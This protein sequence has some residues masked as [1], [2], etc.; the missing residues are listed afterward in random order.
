[1][2]VEKS[3]RVCTYIHSTKDLFLERNKEGKERK[4]RKLNT[5]LE[6]GDSDMDINNDSG[7]G[8]PWT[9]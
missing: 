5:Y 7:G 9:S 2:L 8:G 4:K 1:M 6:K 3:H